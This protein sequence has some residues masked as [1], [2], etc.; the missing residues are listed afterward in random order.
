MSSRTQIKIKQLAVITV[1]WLVVGLLMSI[2][3]HLV[4]LTNN[5]QGLS[6]DYSFA[7]SLSM[8]LTSAVIGS[9]LGGSLL[10]FYV[11]V[12]YLDKPYG[13][14]LLFV[15][16]AF[17]MVILI[18]I[19]VIAMMSIPIKTG[20][21][22]TDEVSREALKTFLMDSS[23]AKNTMIW[24]I[25]VLLTQLL[26][27]VNTKFGQGTLGNIISGKY[28]TPKEENKIFMFLDLDSSTS[29]AEQLGDEKYHELLKDFFAD[30]TNPIL[31]N[32]GEIYQYVGDEVVVAWN[33]RVGIKNNQ[34]IRC[35]FDI[36]QQIQQN[37]EKYLKRYGFI[38]NF[39]GGIHCGK[40]VAGE[41]GII[42]REITYS[43]DVLNTTSRILSMCKNFGAE[44]ITSSNLFTGLKL[45]DS[46]AMTPLGTIKLRGKEKEVTLS[47]IT[48]MNILTC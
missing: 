26:L 16:T 5:S 46:Y 14:T 35:F 45:D 37:K 23:R 19:V 12:K 20:K 29:I 6:A 4:L 39:K 8:N 2:Y 9:M 32:K 18:I 33:Y 13:Y 36:K 27:Q 1:A 38:P 44:I 30:I 42:K 7:L 25:V 41:I 24:S 21:P 43:G 15:A 28:H 11:N 31:D 40:V 34:C 47:A 17:I 3:D 48:Q 10:V 22:F